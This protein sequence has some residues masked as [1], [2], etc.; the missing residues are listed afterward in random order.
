LPIILGDLVVVILVLIN[1]S[2][3]PHLCMVRGRVA[4]LALAFAYWGCLLFC[5]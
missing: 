5:Q 4:I 2:C 3:I 1:S